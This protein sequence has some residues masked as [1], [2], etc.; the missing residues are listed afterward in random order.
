MKLTFKEDLY[1]S[2]CFKLH[3][4]IV[5]VHNGSYKYIEYL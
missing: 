3:V 1:A 2:T 4:L 5:E